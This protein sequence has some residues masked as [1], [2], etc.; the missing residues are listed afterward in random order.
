MMKQLTDA[1]NDTI[2]IMKKMGM[3]STPITV[4]IDK[5]LISRYDKNID[6]FLIHQ[7]E[8]MEQTILRVI[9]L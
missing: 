3:F 2:K 7:K 6:D 4:T 1:M 8:K 9:V 5:H